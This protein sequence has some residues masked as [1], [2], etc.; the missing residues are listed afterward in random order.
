[1]RKKVILFLLV[2][3]ILD[4]VL[5]ICANADYEVTIKEGCRK[6]ICVSKEGVKDCVVCESTPNNWKEE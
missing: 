4:L 2:W 5:V 3:A 6:D 1:M